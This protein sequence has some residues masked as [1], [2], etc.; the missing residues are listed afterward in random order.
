MNQTPDSPDV[1][2]QEASRRRARRSWPA[3]GFLVLG[4]AL[5]VA[6]AAKG[7]SPS[8]RATLGGSS[9]TAAQVRPTV[10][11]DVD[12]SALLKAPL[13]ART[14][15]PST[16]ASARDARPMVVNFWA[17]WCAPCVAEMPLLEAGRR[18]H[19]GIRFVG[20]DEM[21]KPARAEAMAR[22]TGIGYEW[23]L[24][25]NGSV[26]AS[27]E[28]VILPT[29]LY[30]RPDGSIAASRVGAFKSRRDLSQWLDAAQR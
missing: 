29:T 17:E 26:A 5:L 28:T 14:G 9:P 7:S 27:S 10:P 21:D 3:I 24:D 13:R 6:V 22:R 18:T 4:T 15:E 2:P 8:D 20:I 19:P 25:P 23:L 30:I 1:A 12:G 16:V 11:A